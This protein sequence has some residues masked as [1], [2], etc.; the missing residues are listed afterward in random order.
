MAVCIC[1]GVCIVALRSYVSMSHVGGL[2]MKNASVDEKRS[3][4]KLPV[5]EAHISSKLLINLLAL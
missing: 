3:F 4:A 5:F 2:E 1:S